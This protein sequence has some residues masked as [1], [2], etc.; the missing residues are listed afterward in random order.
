MPV[1]A[2]ETSARES[3]QT[4]R[5]R[6]VATQLRKQ[7]AAAARERDAQ[8]ARVRELESQIAQVSK[9]GADDRIALKAAEARSADRGTRLR[10]DRVGPT[11]LAMYPTEPAPCRSPASLG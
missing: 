3:Q 2:E 6:D 9:L 5:L 11:L 10:G 8:F 7:L 4:A 1:T